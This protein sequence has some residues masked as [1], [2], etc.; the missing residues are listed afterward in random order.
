MGLGHG[1][2][3]VF[4]RFE[5]LASQIHRL[6]DAICMAMYSCIDLYAVEEQM[7]LETCL[8]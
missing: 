5:R 4:F 7:R 3:P 6:Y 8:A 2:Y 1:A